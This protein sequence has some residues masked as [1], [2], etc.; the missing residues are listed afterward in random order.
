MVIMKRLAFLLTISIPPI[1]GQILDT[2]EVSDVSLSIAKAAA[3]IEK[4]IESF[5]QQ[6]GHEQPVCLDPVMNCEC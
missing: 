1:S 5:Q 2:F 4:A 6:L 3:N